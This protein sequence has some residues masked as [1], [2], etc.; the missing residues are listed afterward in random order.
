MST[1]TPIPYHNAGHG[2]RSAAEHIKAL[3]NGAGKSGDSISGFA[4][5]VRHAQPGAPA[6]ALKTPR[7]TSRPRD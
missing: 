1:R 3:H 5:P 6:S 7:A 4:K 2:N